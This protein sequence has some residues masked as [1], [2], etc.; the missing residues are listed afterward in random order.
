MVQ[1]RVVHTAIKRRRLGS[2][3]LIEG[4]M[5][6]MYAGSAE[7]HYSA[8]PAVIYDRLRGPYADAAQPSCRPQHRL[9]PSPRS[10]WGA[11]ARVTWSLPPPVT[12]TAGS[13]AWT[14]ATHVRPSARPHTRHGALGSGPPSGTG[15]PGAVCDADRLRQTFDRYVEFNA[16]CELVSS[17]L[18]P[19]PLGRPQVEIAAYQRDQ[20]LFSSK[21]TPTHGAT[22]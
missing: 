22:R 8:H 18:S 4:T 2:V 9:R 6:G 13:Y 16:R 19:D 21:V 20:Q 1:L 14:A 10:L 5:D 3:H 15:E 12:Q 7:A 17:A 11:G